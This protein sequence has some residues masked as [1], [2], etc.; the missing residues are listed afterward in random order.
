MGDIELICDQAPVQ[1]GNRVW[2]DSDR[3]GIQDAGENPIAGVTVRLYDSTGNLAGTAV[4][5]AQGN[6]YFSSNISENASGNGDNAGGGLTANASFTIKVDRNDDYG[7][8]G[9]L[10]GLATTAKD[11]S[12]AQTN[13][14]DL[15]DSDADVVGWKPVIAV[16]CWIRFGDFTRASWQLCVV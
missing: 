14:D 12:N 9:P 16:R 3:D 7:T 8:G 10:V 5:D 6:Y 1:I 4:T 15:I 13:L 2:L 11:Q